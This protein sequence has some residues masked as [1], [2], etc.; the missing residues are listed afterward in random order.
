MT[1]HPFIYLLT[2]PDLSLPLLP[3]CRPPLISATPVV[4]SLHLTV[5]PPPPRRVIPDSSARLGRRVMAGAPTPGCRPPPMLIRRADA[6]DL[7]RGR[8]ER[9]LNHAISIGAAGGLLITPR[10]G[11]GNEE[12]SGPARRCS[13]FAAV[14]GDCGAALSGGAPQ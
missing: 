3:P 8:P 12:Q 2:A 9:H 7:H 14:G 10:A 4:L 1:I 5:P 6:R 11:A 13:F